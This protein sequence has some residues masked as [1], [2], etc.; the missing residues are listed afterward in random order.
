MFDKAIECRRQCH[1][2]GRLGLPHVSDGPRQSLVRCLCPK[3]DTAIFKPLV[4]LVQIGKDRHDLPHAVARILHVLLNLAFLPTCGWI[5]ELGLKHVVAGH[6]LE[7]CIDVPLLAS[8]HTINGGL[9]IVIDP[10]TRHAAEDAECMPVGV[11][12]HL[13]RLQRVGPHQESAAV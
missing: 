9:H 6:S 2:R 5:A 4:Q 7:A 10:A 12:Q 8:A 1:Q 13:V 11:K 3:G